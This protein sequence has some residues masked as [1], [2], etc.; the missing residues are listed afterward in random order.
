M[1]DLRDYCEVWQILFDLAACGWW[2]M[3]LR[4]LL[5]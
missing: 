5:G 1:I 4:L 3:D 2:F